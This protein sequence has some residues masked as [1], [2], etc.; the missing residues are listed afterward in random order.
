MK[1][2]FDLSKVKITDERWKACAD[3][4]ALFLDGM[5]PER[6]LSGFRRTC[7]IETDAEPYGGMNDSLYQVYILTGKKEYLEAAK[8]FWISHSQQEMLLNSSL[9]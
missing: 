2:V 3:K 9:R 1:T 8:I 5:D 4:N 6:V 7:K